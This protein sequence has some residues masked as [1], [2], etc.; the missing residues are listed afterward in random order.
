MPFKR[1]ERVERLDEV[2]PACTR[3]GGFPVVIVP[4]HLHHD[5]SQHELIKD[6]DAAEEAFSVAHEAYS[7]GVVL[8]GKI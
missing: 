3:L 6:P 2:I 8:I 1:S 7:D 5:S 4:A